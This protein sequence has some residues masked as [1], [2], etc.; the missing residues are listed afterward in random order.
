MTLPPLSSTT[1]GCTLRS[2]ARRLSWTMEYW[3]WD[4]ECR[5]A[6]TI[7]LSRTGTQRVDL[8][9]CFEIYFSNACLHTSVMSCS[10]FTNFY[11]LYTPPSPPTYTHSY[12]CINTHTHTCTHTHMHTHT[13]KQKNR[14]KNKQTQTQKQKQ[15]HKKQRKQK[16]DNKKKKYKQQQ[17]Q[18]DREKCR[19]T[20]KVTGGD[21]SG[22]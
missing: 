15:K 11:S 4:T 17:I 21:G 2:S 3:W 7:G 22:K 13:H 10:V 1:V 6:R 8:F 19:K 16:Q 14:N 20:E 5:A 12:T 18:K 9:I